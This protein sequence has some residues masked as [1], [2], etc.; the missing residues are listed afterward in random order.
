MSWNPAV[1]G[2]VNKYEGERKNTAE[3]C[4]FPFVQRE[5]AGR[6]KPCEPKWRGEQTARWIKRHVWLI[7]ASH[8]TARSPLLNALSRLFI[9][10]V[11][12][13]TPINGSRRPLVGLNAGSK[14]LLHRERSPARRRA[15]WGPFTPS[16]RPAVNK[17]VEGSAATKTDCAWTASQGL[18]FISLLLGHEERV[19]FFPCNSRWK[20][21]QRW[22]SVARFRSVS[23]FFFFLFRDRVK[24]SRYNCFVGR[25]SMMWKHSGVW[26]FSSQYRMCWI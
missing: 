8:T 3:T 7:R 22:K 25:K 10:W 16:F 11:Q 9:R 2:A 18:S 14:H 4:C 13:Q 23:A 6:V 19:R 20:R 15:P 17:T 12:L 21:L 24:C 1:Y 26:W 5:M